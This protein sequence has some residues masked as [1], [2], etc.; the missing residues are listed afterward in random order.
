[1]PVD[2][3]ALMRI[4]QIHEDAGER[5]AAI[6]ALETLVS[7]HPELAGPQFRLGLFYYEAGRYD[8]AIARFEAVARSGAGAEGDQ[9]RYENEVRYFIGLVH[10]EAGRSDAALAEFE[11]VPPSSPR[12]VDARTAMA[13]LYERGK[14]YERASTELRRAIA[15]APDKLSL[16]VYLAGLMQRSGDLPGAVAIMES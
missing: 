14:D 1:M 8:D 2:P 4:A 10:E 6:Q 15:A 16:Q 13:R 11:Q 7:E 3:A 12:F 9:A 5:A